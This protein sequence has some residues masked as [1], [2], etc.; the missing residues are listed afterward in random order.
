LRGTKGDDNLIG[1][2]GND[3]LFGG[4]RDKLLGGPGKEIVVGG[5]ERPLGGS[6]KILSGDLGN[7]GV[8]AGQGSEIALGGAGNDYLQDGL[9]P[10]S[11]KDNLSGGPGNDVI[12]GDHVPAFEDLIVCG[13]GFDWVLADSRDVVAPDCETVRIVQGSR[14]QVRQQEERFFESIPQSFFE[15]LPPFPQ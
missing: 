5:S 13:P 15:G 11:S 14:K 10:E 8:F 12:V 9:F 6:D 1:K 7:D 3:N 2:G 4:G